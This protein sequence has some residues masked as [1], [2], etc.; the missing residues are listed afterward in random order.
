M[1]SP[2]FDGFAGFSATGSGAAVSSATW[3]SISFRQIPGITG[4]GEDCTGHAKRDKES[5]PKK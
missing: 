5:K 2:L 1:M 4:R 3:A